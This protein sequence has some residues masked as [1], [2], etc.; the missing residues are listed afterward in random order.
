[1][2][3]KKQ[4]EQCEDIKGRGVGHKWLRK[5]DTITLAFTC[6]N[7]ASIKRLNVAPESR[8]TPNN[9]FRR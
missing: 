6:H 3:K 2:I 7:Q 9:I 5:G 4:N 1:M 8:M